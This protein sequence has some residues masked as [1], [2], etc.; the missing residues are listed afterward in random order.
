MSIGIHVCMFTCAYLHVC[1]RFQPLIFS[2]HVTHDRAIAKRQIVENR[3][4]REENRGPRPLSGINK[5]P[6]TGIA[7][8]LDSGPGSASLLQGK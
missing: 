6:T 2:F 8:I 3:K 4:I 5:P 7:Q 1:L